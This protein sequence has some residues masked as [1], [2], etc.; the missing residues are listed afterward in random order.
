MF[1]GQNNKCE[2]QNDL[3]LIRPEYYTNKRMIHEVKFGYTCKDP[4]LTLNAK[5]ITD[6]AG[7]P[8]CARIGAQMVHLNIKRTGS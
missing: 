4:E 1:G 5:Q 8:P 7:Q 3:W 6:F 2:M